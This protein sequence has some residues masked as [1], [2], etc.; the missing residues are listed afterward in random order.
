MTANSSARQRG[1]QIILEHE[2]VKVEDL[3]IYDKDDDYIGLDILTYNRKWYVFDRRAGG[4]Y[5]YRECQAGEV[6]GLDI[7]GRSK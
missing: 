7:V 6:S 3:Y 2:D 4:A 5:V 1:C